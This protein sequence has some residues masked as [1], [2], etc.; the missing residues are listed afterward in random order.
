MTATEISPGLA[1]LLEQVPASGDL[2]TVTPRQL[3]RG[4]REGVEW[5]RTRQTGLR[6]A[7]RELL[8]R[9]RE[10]L[11]QVLLD[12]CSVKLS[13]SPTAS[14][15]SWTVNPSMDRAE[16]SR[17]L[18]SKEIPRHVALGGITKA[19]DLVRAGTVTQLAFLANRVAPSVRGFMIQAV[20]CSLNRSQPRTALQLF[21]RLE[22]MILDPA[23][24]NRLANNKAQALDLLGRVEAALTIVRE[25][26]L[27]SS[28]TTAVSLFGYGAQ[29]GA[30]EDM[31][32]GLEAF[33]NQARLQPE[34]ARAL[35]KGR[36]QAVRDGSWVPTTIARALAKRLNSKNDSW[37]DELLKTLL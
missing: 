33:S 14:R 5:A 9:H 36:S 22:G 11:A 20:D 35:V 32:L 26:G 31:R 25:H 18:W 8:L 3:V 12:A 10:E 24:G 27:R 28:L 16:S 15:L 17:R 13:D 19:A 30:E 34:Q 29:V 21:G 7:E 2:M 6:A 4:L 37:Q 1:E 23:A